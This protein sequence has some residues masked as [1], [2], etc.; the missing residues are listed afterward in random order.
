MHLVAMKILGTVFRIE[1]TPWD[2]RNNLR[3]LALG[4]GGFATCEVVLPNP[5]SL[6]TVAPQPA[7]LH[8]YRIVQLEDGVEEIDLYDGPKLILKFRP[9]T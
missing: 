4:A 3:P 2:Y 5:D 6:I 1:G 8:F 7:E 9:L